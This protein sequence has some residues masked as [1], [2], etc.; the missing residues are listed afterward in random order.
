[1]WTQVNQVFTT[2]HAQNAWAHLASDN[3]WHKILPNAA[4]GV[5]NVH[6]LLSL[7]RANGKQAFVVLDAAKNITQAYL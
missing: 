6:L 1:M 4:D 2:H 3:A 7:A 5:T